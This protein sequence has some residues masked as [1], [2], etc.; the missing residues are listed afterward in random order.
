M[1]PLL[2]LA[3]LLLT[4]ACL[5]AHQDAPPQPRSESAP[6]SLQPALPPPNDDGGWV[7]GPDGQPIFIGQPEPNPPSE[8]R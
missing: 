6:A 4:T 5:P 1:K 3:S 7:I 8:R 2:A